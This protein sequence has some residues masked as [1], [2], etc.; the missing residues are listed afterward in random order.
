MILRFPALESGAS[1][2]GQAPFSGKLAL[3]RDPIAST[4]GIDRTMVD[5][6][7]S[8]AS[9]MSFKSFFAVDRQFD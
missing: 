1:L 9:S 7:D 3:Y 4:K 6:G 8:E 5:R 2:T